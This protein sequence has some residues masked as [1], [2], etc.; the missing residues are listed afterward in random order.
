MSDQNDNMTGSQRTIWG[1][2]VV[3]IV[4]LVIL[5]SF[6]GTGMGR[7]YVQPEDLAFVQL[8]PSVDNATESATDPKWV[9]TDS[10]EGKAYI[11]ANPD[12][13]II[14][15]VEY[16][17]AAPSSYFRQQA[18][19][20]S[21]DGGGASIGMNPIIISWPRT[22]GLWVA[23]FFTLAI[24]SFLYRDNPFYKFAESVV[25]GVSAGYWMVVGFWDV[26][27][28]NLVQRLLPVF[29]KSYFTPG[30]ELPGEWSAYWPNLFY[31]IPLVLG[32]MLILRLVP[33]CGWLSLWPLAFIVGT[34]AGL[35]LVGYIEGDFLSQIK[36][37]IVPLYVEGTDTTTTFR[38]YWGTFW[39]SLSNILIVVGVLA[40][41]VYFF[42]SIEHKGVVGGT[43]RVGIWY[44]MITFGA[45]FGFTVM[46][47]IALLA[48][49]VEFLF[50]DW[51]W[52]IDP[53]QQRVI[54]E[55]SVGLLL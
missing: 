14:G 54:L 29:S 47:R 48:A 50:D 46:G 38:T 9:R 45:A 36:A 19:L 27:I 4:G 15:W 17:P 39:A 13:E 24:F 44:L 16:A 35:R 52:L 11:E 5:R 10:E 43:A 33:K 2:I 8:A 7:V 23:A 22:I 41:L 20:A 6:I 26:I 37:S 51:M 53:N 12:A 3:A 30:M 40:T 28:P 25:V 42:F 31:I 32:I 55:A 49:R 1:V 21:S 34:M 18:S